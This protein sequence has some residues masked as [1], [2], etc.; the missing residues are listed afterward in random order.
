VDGV[1]DDAAKRSIRSGFA[2]TTGGFSAT[3]G[4][5]AIARTDP[6][7]IAQIETKNNIQLR[8]AFP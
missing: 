8:M 3:T 5:S 2:T 7:G 6:P 1:W 4:G